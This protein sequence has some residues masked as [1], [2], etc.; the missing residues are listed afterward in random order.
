MTERERIALG[1]L[2]YLLVIPS[3]AVMYVVGFASSGSGPEGVV[4]RIVAAVGLLVIG[5]IVVFPLLGRV[6]R[7]RVGRLQRSRRMAECCENCGY[8]RAGL[9]GD[10]CPECGHVNRW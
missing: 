9:P 8:P 4:R 3:L 1:T 10:R 5:A 6:R 7:W 2:W